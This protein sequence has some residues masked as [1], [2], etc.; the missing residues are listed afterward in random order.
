[1]INE[2]FDK[3]YILNLH[4]RV[5]RK[6]LIEKKLKFFEIT[7]YEIFGGTD[8]S[9]LYP[10]WKNFS[11]TNKNFSNPNYLG[12]AISHLSIYEDALFKGYSRILILEDDF[13]IK[14]NFNEAFE[15]SIKQVPSD[16]NNLLYLGFIPLSDD[17][18]RW[19]YSVFSD[20]FINSNT[21]IAKNLWG[22][23]SYG[24]SEN[25]MMSVLSE[26]RENFPMELDRY[27]VTT[28]QPENMSYAI[29]PQLF[30]AEDNLSDNSHVFENGLLEKSIDSRFA[31]LQDYI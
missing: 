9:V 5:D 23:Y 28:I 7:N 17:L 2:Y 27:F 1:M 3:I 30:S 20:K 15:Y 11:K 13:R 22:L 14:R 8:G 4:K 21:F 26:Y 25:L 6:I 10:I 24:I 18:S 19:D 16:W 29:T 31:K 12:C